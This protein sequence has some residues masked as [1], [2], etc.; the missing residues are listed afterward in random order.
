MS[1]KSKKAL[2]DAGFE[3]ISARFRLLG[4][5]L[6]L[7]LLHSLQ[8]GERSVGELV[9]ATGTSQP[10]AS[11]QLRALHTAGLLS[12]RQEG[13]TVY[14]EVADPTIFDLCEIV[15]GGIERDLE[16]RAKAFR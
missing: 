12:R 6:R 11:K 1:E 7:K 5:P 16:Q 10:N 15:C 9:M 4:E 3:E 8:Q 13:T 14:Y 2:T